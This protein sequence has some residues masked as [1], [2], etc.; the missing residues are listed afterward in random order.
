MWFKLLTLHLTLLFHHSFI[1]YILGTAMKQATMS[2]ELPPQAAK[3][4]PLQQAAPAVL[5]VP[6]VAICPATPAVN[7]CDQQQIISCSSSHQQSSSSS[8]MSATSVQVKEGGKFCSLLAT[9][10]EMWCQTDRHKE[11]AAL[12][13]NIP[14]RHSIFI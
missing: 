8:S 7:E 11:N 4:P 6:Q 3:P 10:L 14:C 2:G 12:L 13:K 1:P 9:T 5:E